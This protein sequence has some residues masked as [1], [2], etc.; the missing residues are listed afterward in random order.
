MCYTRVVPV[1]GDRLPYKNTLYVFFRVVPVLVNGLPKKNNFT[2]TEPSIADR[3]ERYHQG[4]PGWRRGVDG[5]ANGSQLRCCPAQRWGELSLLLLLFSVVVV[6]GGG[7]CV[8]G[9]G[10][11]VVVVVVVS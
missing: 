10:S 4:A 1:F 8:G 11:S 3:G 5:R 2:L 6:V 7:A 9:G